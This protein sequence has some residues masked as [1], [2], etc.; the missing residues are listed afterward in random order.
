MM[1]TPEADIFVDPAD[2]DELP[3]VIDDFDSEFNAGSKGWMEQF[4]NQQK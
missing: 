3:D 2:M 4:E 1:G